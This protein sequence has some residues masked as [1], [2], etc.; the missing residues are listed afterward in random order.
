MSGQLTKSRA[1]GSLGT[2]VVWL[3]RIALSPALAPER[4]LELLMQ[5]LLLLRPSI[6]P[7]VDHHVVVT[8]NIVELVIVD[9]GRSKVPASWIENIGKLRIPERD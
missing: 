2:S 8:A 9:C 6:S 5:Q 7:D 3:G 4:A 1:D